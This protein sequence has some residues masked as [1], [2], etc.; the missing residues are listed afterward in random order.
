MADIL[1]ITKEKV[2]WQ[3]GVTDA[4]K[5]AALEEMVVKAPPTPPYVLPEGDENR[6][7]FIE[8]VSGM[9]AEYNRHRPAHGDSWRWEGIELSQLHQL[10]KQSL[11]GGLANLRENP[12]HCFDIGNF[13]W[14]IYIRIKKGKG[15]T[16]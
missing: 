12:E 16:F 10:F 2:V 6:A 4:E 7:D 11:I 15:A 1:C 5:I 13:L 3:P 8:F 9:A 14:F